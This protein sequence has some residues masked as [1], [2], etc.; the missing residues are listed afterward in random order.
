MFS[1]A[2]VLDRE[3]WGLSWNMVLGLG[4]LLV[5]KEIRLDFDVE[6]GQ[7]PQPLDRAQAR[8][9]SDTG[10]LRP[11]PTRSSR[12]CGEL[13]TGARGLR[14]PG[15]VSAGARRTIDSAEVRVDHD[16]HDGIGEGTG[17]VRRHEQPAAY[18]DAR[19]PGQARSVAMIGTQA[20]RIS[21][22]K[23]SG[24]LRA[25]SLGTD[26]FGGGVGEQLRRR[27]L[28][29]VV[30]LERD[31]GGDA[32]QPAALDERVAVL[33]PSHRR[34]CSWFAGPVTT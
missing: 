30:A 33:L 34:D 12:R 9:T 13:G 2:G 21:S 29:I 6:I 3:Q 1:A 17:V 32:A 24:S 23:P 7:R 28:V 26:D 11:C 15:T 4:G 20:A 27:R 16:P 22:G 14:R 25:A 5:S 8:R 10:G 19:R 18:R 31:P